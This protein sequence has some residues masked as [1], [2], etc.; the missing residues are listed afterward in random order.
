VSEGVMGQA[1]GG[2]MT[3]CS[4]SGRTDWQKA[5][6][7]SPVLGMRLR[8]AAKAIRRQSSNGEI[9]GVEAIGGAPVVWI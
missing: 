7:T 5:W 9:T 2:R 4:S 6:L 3:Y 8:L 1:L